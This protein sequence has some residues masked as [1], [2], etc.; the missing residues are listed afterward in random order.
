MALIGNSTYFCQEGFFRDELLP[1]IYLWA[2]K[3]AM[4]CFI[5][6]VQVM[7]RFFSSLPIFFW[8]IAHLQV[9]SGQQKGRHIISSDF[10]IK[11]FVVALTVHTI[12]FACFYP[13]A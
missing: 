6:H 12:L 5:M 1:F 11:Y 8:F 7:I 3:L 13:P 4:C 2:F 9:Q 10:V